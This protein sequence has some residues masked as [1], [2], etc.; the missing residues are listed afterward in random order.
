MLSDLAITYE[1]KEQDEM[2][3]TFSGRD[4]IKYLME[5]HDLSDSDIGRIVGQR[6]LGSK[7]VKGQR[8]INRTHAKLL[9]ERFGIDHLVF[10]RE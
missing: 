10:L 2:E 7:L 6:E 3:R 9:G 4:M 1:D 5:T 8:R